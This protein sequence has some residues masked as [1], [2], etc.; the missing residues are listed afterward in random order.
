MRPG[1][2]A[3]APGLP[4]DAPQDQDRPAADPSPEDRPPAPREYHRQA[5][6]GRL[7][8]LGEMALFAIGS[9]VLFG[10]ALGLTEATGLA[11]PDG[12]SDLKDPL[13]DL[14]FWFALIAALL[15]PLAAAVRLAGGRRL[16]T[17]SSVAGRLRWAWLLACLPYALV[18]AGLLVAG[19][20]VFA[21]DDG[22]ADGWPGVGTY[23]LIAATAVLVVPF[24]AA[25]EE[26]IARGWF[27]QALASW[28]RSR[29]VA[30][31][32][33]SALF[34]AAHGSTDPGRLADLT[35]FALAL[36][37]LTF[38]TGG[39]EAGIALHLAVNGVVLLVT[40]VEGIPDTATE[41]DEEM[42]LALSAISI[43]LTLGYTA[44]VSW[45]WDRRGGP[46]RS[47]SVVTA[48]RPEPT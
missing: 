22:P 28:V 34:V 12:S 27:V 14:A 9:I 15:L 21:P 26:Y 45:L 11:K 40:G 1:V 41:G 37:W 32:V 19:A 10:A 4:Q 42:P 36:C 31:A 6:P 47:P 35:V 48:S 3:A 17:V 20:V 5:T 38:R 7:R 16:G 23:L 24:Q 39:L 43:A 18:A 44:M 30:A 46:D 25:A 29:W 33:A 2:D 13:A 8:P